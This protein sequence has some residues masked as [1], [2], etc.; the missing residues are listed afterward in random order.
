MANTAF[1]RFWNA[2]DDLLAMYGMAG[3][4]FG[5]ASWLYRDAVGLAWDRRA[6]T[7][8]E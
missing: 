8:G 6:A 2:Q 1:M 4:T 5:E 7:G 3:L